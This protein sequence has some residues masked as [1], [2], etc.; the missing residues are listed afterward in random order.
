MNII[1][2]VVTPKGQTHVGT[3]GIADA[4]CW[5]AIRFLEEALGKRIDK[6]LTAEFYS[7]VSTR[8]HNQQRT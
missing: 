3:K 4:E 8:E 2:I 7:N 1:E 5:Q 6:Q